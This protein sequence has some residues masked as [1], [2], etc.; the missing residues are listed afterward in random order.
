MSLASLWQGNDKN[1]KKSMKIAN[2]DREIL[3]IFWTTW[4]IPMKF[5]GKM[6][7]MII[8]KV[9]KNQDFTLSLEDTFFEKNTEKGG[10]TELP[11]LP[12]ILRLSIQETGKW[13]QWNWLL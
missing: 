13:S 3:G 7:L 9:I 4:G 6:W 12:A 1:F 11:P 5:S 2:V 8:L 10:Q